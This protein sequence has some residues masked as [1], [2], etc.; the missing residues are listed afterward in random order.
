M[1]VLGAFLFAVGLF[2]VAV[3]RNNFLKQVL[4]IDVM[5]LG[6][7]V[8]FVYF[9]AFKPVDMMGGQTAAMIVMVVAALE[10]VLA[11][12]ILVMY[13]NKNRNIN[14]VASP[15]REREG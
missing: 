2:G 8:N 12:A 10:V 7:V 11:L 14:V 15:P 5:I 4:C 9:S 6:A 3:N 1:I 13:Y